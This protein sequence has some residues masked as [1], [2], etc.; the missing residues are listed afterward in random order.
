MFVSPIGEKKGEL[1][2]FVNEKNLIFSL[3]KVS[4]KANPFHTKCQLQMYFVT[5]FAAVKP[6]ECEWHQRWIEC[7]KQ[8]FVKAY[9]NALK[10]L[11]NGCFYFEVHKYRYQKLRVRCEVKFWVL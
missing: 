4:D 1:N 11:L 6:Q 2:T 9:K 8:P 10:I 7:Q 5:R 3:L